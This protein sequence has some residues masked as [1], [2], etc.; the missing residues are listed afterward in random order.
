MDRER[1]DKKRRNEQ[2]ILSYAFREMDYFKSVSFWPP[3]NFPSSQVPAHFHSCSSK[4]LDPLSLERSGLAFAD[5]SYLLSHACPHILGPDR[6]Y[7]SLPE[8]PGVRYSVRFPLVQ[9]STGD[10]APTGFASI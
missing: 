3:R 5:I 4:Y 1:K 6:I 2:L 10:I 7:C 8:C 9:V